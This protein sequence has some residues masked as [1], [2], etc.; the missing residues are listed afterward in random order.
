MSKLH[1]SKEKKS[2]EREVQNIALEGIHICHVDD[3]VYGGA[4]KFE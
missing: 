1:S 3:I 2:R 4:N